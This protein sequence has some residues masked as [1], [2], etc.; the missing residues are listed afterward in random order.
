MRLWPPVLCCDLLSGMRREPFRLGSRWLAP[1]CQPCDEDLISVAQ[2]RTGL[3]VL[4]ACLGNAYLSTRPSL[5]SR[6][7]KYCFGSSITFAADVLASASH[8]VATP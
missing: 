2:R 4:F 6:R 8:D 3:A 1:R 7:S 5:S